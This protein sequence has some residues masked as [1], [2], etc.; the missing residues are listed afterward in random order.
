VTGSSP[1][2]AAAHGRAPGAVPT[3]GALLAELVAALGDRRQARWVLAAAAGVG[4]GEL[5][6]G[7]HDEVPDAVAAEARRMASRRLA[8]EPLQYVL[9]RWAFRTLEVA[10]DPRV[11]VPRPE[12]EQLVESALGELIRIAGSAHGPGPSGNALSVVDLGTGSGVVALSLAAEFEG[13]LEVWATDL[14]ADALEVARANLDVLAADRP[15]AA[16]RVRLVRGSWF[17]ALP[18]ALAGD[19]AVVVSNPPYVSAGEWE[20]LDAVVRDHEPYDALVPGPTGLEAVERIVDEA[21]AWLA[22]GGAL[23]CELAPHQARAVLA[24]TRRRGYA[25]AEIRRDLAGLERLLVARWRG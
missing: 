25:H 19:A 4:P 9:G 7:A 15:E 22:P 17:A 10:V 3:G 20:R 8:G 1:A 16:A 18:A 6:V 21:P 13:P 2:D 11:L 12:T 14:S 5:L 24:A 23:V